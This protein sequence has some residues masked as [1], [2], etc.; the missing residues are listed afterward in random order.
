MLVCVSAESSRS[1]CVG[2]DVTQRVS[3]V[4]SHYWWWRRAARRTGLALFDRGQPVGEG[5]NTGSRA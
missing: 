1:E 4:T 3:A 5:A 2:R